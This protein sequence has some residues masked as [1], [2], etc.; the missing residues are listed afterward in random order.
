MSDVFGSAG[1]SLRADMSGSASG[2]GLHREYFSGPAQFIVV[3]IGNTS[4][5][6]APEIQLPTEP[7]LV[8][9]EE[10]LTDYQLHSVHKLHWSRQ[11]RDFHHR[12]TIWIQQRASHF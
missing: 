8:V 6:T 9:E 7:L 3:A 1:D 10:S 5:N 12:K 4:A 11:L 2:S